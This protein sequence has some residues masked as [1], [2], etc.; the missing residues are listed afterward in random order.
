MKTAHQ[1]AVSNGMKLYWERRRKRQKD[2][3][4]AA[5]VYVHAIDNGTQKQADAAWDL[6]TKCVYDAD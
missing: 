4:D 3:A 6:L 2:I 5:V 1:I